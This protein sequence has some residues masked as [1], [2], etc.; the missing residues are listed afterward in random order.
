MLGFVFMGFVPL[1]H[2]DVRLH[3]VPAVG[4]GVAPL[5]GA[6]FGLGW[7][8]CVSPALGAVLSL[9]GTEGTAARGAVLSLAYSFGL[10]V[11]FVVA[12]LAF[13]RSM[14]AL[15]WVRTHQR[16][17]SVAGGGLLVVVGLMMV[18]GAYDAVVDSLRTLLGTGS[19]SV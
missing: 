7:I 8:P 18:T 5:L 10:G 3:A 11:P 19:I 15:T 6:L 14:A 16:A 2:R 4:V 9:A 17:F 12:A 1:M 13:T